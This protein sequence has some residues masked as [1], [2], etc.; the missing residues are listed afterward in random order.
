MLLAAAAIAV[1]LVPLAL[2]YV[3]L[4]YD[5]D[6]AGDDPAAPLS[7]AD[8]VLERITHNATSTVAGEY[9][10]EDRERAAATL[11]ERLDRETEELERSRLSSGVAYEVERN[12]SAAGRW[13]DGHCPSGPDRAFGPCEAID[14]IVLQERAGETAVVAVAFDVHAT[15]ERG[16]GEMTTVVRPISGD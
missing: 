13:A 12:A 7:D 6:V 16:R 9:D 15:T 3:G 5:A 1:A 10:W 4:G 2:A 8:R 14:G 11:G